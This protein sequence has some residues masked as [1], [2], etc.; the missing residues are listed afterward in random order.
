MIQ[1]ERKKTKT[2]KKEPERDLL[3]KMGVFRTGH[4]EGVGGGAKGPP[5]L[6]SVTHILQ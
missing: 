5:S 2:R 3:F 6:K 1:K 4:G